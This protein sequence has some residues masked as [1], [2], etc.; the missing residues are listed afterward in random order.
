VGGVAACLSCPGICCAAHA[1]QTL[2]WACC[3]GEGFDQPWP[4]LWPALP[5]PRPP[6]TAADSSLL[7]P[8]HPA[9]LPTPPH[10]RRPTRCCTLAPTAPWSSCPASRWA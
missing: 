8:S 10:P 1:V 4:A 7:P 2:C 9:P 6:R 5:T 3:A